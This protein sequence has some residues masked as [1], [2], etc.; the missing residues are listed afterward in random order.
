MKGWYKH[1]ACAAR[2]W[3]GL[4]MPKPV[5]NDEDASADWWLDA[6]RSVRTTEWI[7]VR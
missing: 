2:L 3:L 7:A 5:A 4:D 6:G 1:G